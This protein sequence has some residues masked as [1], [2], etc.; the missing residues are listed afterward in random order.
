MENPGTHLSLNEQLQYFNGSM[1]TRVA[2]SLEA[3]K[4]G[5][6]PWE[7]DLVVKG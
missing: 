7:R 3:M 5:A 1:E 4:P 6:N 2:S